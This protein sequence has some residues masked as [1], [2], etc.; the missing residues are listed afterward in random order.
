MCIAPQY[1][2]GGDTAELVTA[3]HYRLVPHPPGYPLYVW[4]QFLWTHAFPFGTLFWKASLLS[5]LFGILTL[6]IT[7]KGVRNI[8][9][10][11]LIIVLGTYSEFVE[12]SVLPDVFSLH[13]LIVA[14][15]FYSFLRDQ[16]FLVPFLFFLGVS[17]HHTIIFLLPCLVISFIEGLKE[18]NY[19]SYLYGAMTGIIVTG[20]L[21]LSLFFMQ[22]EHPLSWGN[23]TDIKSLVNHILRSD[24]GTFKLSV[25]EKSAGLGPFF[26]LIKS[27]LPL[28]MISC[29]SFWFLFKESRRFIDRKFCG[30]TLT[31]ILTLMFPLLMNIA[32]ENIG[33]E[34]LRRFHVMP[35]LTLVTWLIYV[36]EKQEITGKRARILL[37]T[38]IPALA[39]NIFHL[40]DFWGLRNDPV[41]EEYARNLYE[42]GK[43][44][45]PSLIFADTDS[46]FFGLRYMM[47]TDPQSDINVVSA[48]LL[49]HEWFQAKIKRIFPEFFVPE[50]VVRD[51]TMNISED[52]IRPN[53]DKI[54]F[55]MVND[56]KGDD[57]YH[58]TF[59]RLGRVVR[60]GEGIDF[61]DD[62]INHSFYDLKTGPQAFTKAYLYSHYSHFFMARYY[63]FENTAD[64][65]EAVRVVPY[66][67]YA[68]AILCEKQGFTA[69]NC[70]REVLDTLNKET[71]F[72]FQ[73]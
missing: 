39:L 66:A 18:E 71:S 26:Y 47:M 48:E 5:A 38:F 56:Y 69:K 43:N 46:S 62:K 45:R 52:V 23:L 51:R 40:K 53:F 30:L 65:E 21:Y 54:H 28:L 3:G 24:Y 73:R 7:F 60:K 31:L 70:G 32:P 13:A 22:P 67:Y 10:F 29:F 33:R 49:F 55:V 19:R 8:L 72:I 63:E 42:T 17:N 12:S 27:L 68:R 61:V 64:L 44:N 58:V 41:I 14:A 16:K 37:L 57:W 15:F 6:L 36:V 34:V 25:S 50:H 11:T 35:L 1:I 4:A 9:A 59:H 2:Q 20:G